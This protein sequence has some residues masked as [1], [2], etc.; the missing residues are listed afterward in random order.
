MFVLLIYTIRHI[1]YLTDF[2]IGFRRN[3]TRRWAKVFCRFNWQGVQKTVFWSFRKI[4]SFRRIKVSDCPFETFHKPLLLFIQKD[5]VFYRSLNNFL[6]S[7]QIKRKII[8][9]KKEKLTKT[10]Q[11]SNLKCY[12]THW[13]NVQSF[14]NFAIIQIKRPCANGVNAIKQNIAP[15]L[16]I[17]R[18]NVEH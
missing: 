3:W 12:F 6:F 10:K 13:S 14:K 17:H 1:I 16:L 4:W 15:K 2:E 8:V 18:E 9:E 11:I 7:S 5:F